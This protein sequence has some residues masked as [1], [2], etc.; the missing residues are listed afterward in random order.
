MNVNETA[1]SFVEMI[2][3]KKLGINGGSTAEAFTEG[4]A[5]A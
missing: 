3:A 4:L 2:G 1:L 5:M